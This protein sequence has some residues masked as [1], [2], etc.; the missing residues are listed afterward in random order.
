MGISADYGPSRSGGVSGDRGYVQQH[1]LAVRA[2]CKERWRTMMV[3]KVDHGIT[4]WS[5]LGAMFILGWLASSA[6]HATNTADKAVV[7]LKTVETK[8]IPTLKSVLGCQERR[9]DVLAGNIDSNLPTCPSAK[10]ALKVP[11]TK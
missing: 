2:G 11:D 5:K 9:A 10:N 6:Y 8:T 3:E 7:Q 4:L 1:I